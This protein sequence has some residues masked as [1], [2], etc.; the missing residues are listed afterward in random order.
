M[1]KKIL[2]VGLVVSL[3]LVVAVPVPALAAAPVVFSAGGTVTEVTPG[4]IFPAGT[5]GRWVVDERQMS[6]LIAGS[7]NGEYTLTYSANMDLETQAGS[8]HGTISVD[9]VLINVTGKSQLVGLG[10]PG[11]LVEIAPDVFIPTIIRSLET[12]GSWTLISGSVGNG[13]YTGL[14]AVVIAA[15]GPVEGHILD[16][17]PGY[18]YFTMTGKWKP[19]AN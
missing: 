12:A 4:D 2:L 16:I 10:S 8:F 13:D 14:T 17:V 18:S 1:K 5:S 11:P 19:L 15:A 7:I 9:S 3:T 6:G